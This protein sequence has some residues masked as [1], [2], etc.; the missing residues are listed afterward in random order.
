MSMHHDCCIII[1]SCAS[2]CFSHIYSNNKNL[3]IIWCTAMLWTI[4]N[5]L[6]RV[7]LVSLVRSCY[8][9]HLSCYLGGIVIVQ[10][11]LQKKI[12]YSAHEKTPTLNNLVVSKWNPKNK[13]QITCLC[14]YFLALVCCAF[15][16]APAQLIVPHSLTARP[17]QVSLCTC[18]VKK[19]VVWCLVAQTLSRPCFFP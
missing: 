15:G 5:V 3:W 9:F 2:T 13:Y 12:A 19:N 17:T 16:N 10:P 6:P 7:R 1:V 11:F 8:V 14:W 18:Y 4:R